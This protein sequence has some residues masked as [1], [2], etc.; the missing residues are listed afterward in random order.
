LDVSLSGRFFSQA[1][2]DGMIGC[3]FLIGAPVLICGLRLGEKYR[4]TVFLLVLHGLF[5]LAMTHQVRFLLP[6][7]ALASALMAA[8]VGS[9]HNQLIR[10]LAMLLL[11]AAMACN[12]SL[13]GKHFAS[14]DALRF[15]LGLESRHQFLEREVAGD[16]YAVF[17]HIEEELPESSRI[18]FGSCGNPG[19]LCKRPY[20]S[21]ALFENHTLARYL[22]EAAEPSDLQALLFGAGFTHLLFRFENV[23]DPSGQRSEVPLKHQELLASFLNS[24]GRLECQAAGTF[25][26]AIAPT[27]PETPRER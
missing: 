11:A 9:L 10:R 27:P 1:H 25:L 4:I 15:V 13:I 12:V 16:D 14:H 3:A 5:W 24:Y 23:F 22:R 26:Y 8:A 19:F 2:F 17:R 21:D 7:L 6:A 18:L 20:Y